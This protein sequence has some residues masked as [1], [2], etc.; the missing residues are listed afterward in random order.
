MAILMKKLLTAFLI[1]VLFTYLITA[2]IQYWNGKSVNWVGNI[3]YS[4]A[5]VAIIAIFDWLF[6]DFKCK[7][8]NR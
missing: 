8:A 4:L 5:L 6:G 7:K 3:G 2:G 1:T